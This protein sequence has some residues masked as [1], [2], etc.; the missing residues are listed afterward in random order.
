MHSQNSQVGAEV[1][2][3]GLVRLG[4]LVPQVVSLL[5]EDLVVP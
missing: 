3:Q 2:L 1:Y 4:L 5:I